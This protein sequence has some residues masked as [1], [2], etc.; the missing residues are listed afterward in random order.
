[1][2]EGMLKI[3]EEQLDLSKKFLFVADEEFH[4]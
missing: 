2:Q 4:E 3:A 1:M